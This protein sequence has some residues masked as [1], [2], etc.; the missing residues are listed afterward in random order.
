MT[1]TERIGLAQTASL[2]LDDPFDDAVFKVRQDADERAASVQT[3]LSWRR[4]PPPTPSS[5]RRPR[6]PGQ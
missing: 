2:A 3:W 1:L 6:A 5:G 4:Q